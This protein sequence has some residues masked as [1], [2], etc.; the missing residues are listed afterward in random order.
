MSG[1]TTL[2]KIDLSDLLQSLNG[3]DQRRADDV[4]Y[5]QIYDE[6]SSGFMDKVAQ[7]RA[8]E[9]SNGNQDAIKSAY[10][11][12]R[13]IRIKD[14]LELLRRQ[15]QRK[16]SQLKKRAKAYEAAQKQAVLDEKK[17]QEELDKNRYAKF[18]SKPLR[19]RNDPTINSIDQAS[20]ELEEYHRRVNSEGGN[21]LWL[22]F[23]VVL[24]I[25]ITMMILFVI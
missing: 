1:K 9:A 11:R 7:A 8:I 5:A 25:L 6:Y 12:F 18:K 23:G 17:R 3:L 14:D 4:I 15:T 2:E 16:N 22:W 21:A 13:F 10:I 19:E 24:S 20:L